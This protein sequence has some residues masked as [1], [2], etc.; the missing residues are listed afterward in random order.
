MRKLYFDID[1]T[2]L[3]L[4]FG[5]PKPALVGG[6]FEHAVREAQIDALV[7]IGNFAEVVRAMRTANPAYD[8]LGAVFTL[9][10]GMFGDEAWFRAVTQFVSD[11][12]RRAAEIRLEEDWWYVDD[13]AEKYF[14]EVGRADVFTQNLG[15]RILRPSPSGTGEGVLAWIRSMPPPDSSASSRGPRG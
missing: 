6:A 12:R 13:D 3:L 8:G 11:P 1:G 7:C 9:C 5:A 14:R 2:L 15:G 4:N 10:D